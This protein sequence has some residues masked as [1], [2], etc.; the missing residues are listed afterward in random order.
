M[1]FDSCN[2]P[3]K[4]WESIGSPIPKVGAHL[5]VWRFI[6]SHFPILPGAWNVT[7]GLHS[8]LAPLQALYIWSYHWTHKDIGSKQ[9]D[10]KK[11]ILVTSCWSIMA[12]YFCCFLFIFCYFFTSCNFYK[13]FFTI[14]GGQTLFCFVFNY[15]IN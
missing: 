15:L 5:G 7:L 4:I 8:W 2:S 9:F 10:H 3:L 1:S 12:G 14:E 11:P 6:P 13:L